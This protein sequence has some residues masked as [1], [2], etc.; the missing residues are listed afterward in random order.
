M[1]SDKKP[2]LRGKPL[3]ITHPELV[4]QWDD[5]YYSPN[6]LSFGSEVKIRWKCQNCQHQWVRSPNAR[7]STGIVG[8][9]PVCVSGHLHSDGRNSLANTHP[10]ISQDFHPTKNIDFDANE[11]VAGTSK[12]IWWKC[13]VC[14]FEWK[15]SGAHRAN[16]GRNCKACNNQA[17]KPDKS[18]SLAIAYPNL[19]E[20][21][22]YS[23]NDH[24]SPFE[25]T[26]GGTLKIWWKCK[27]CDH[28]WKGRISHRSY[29]GAGCPCCSGNDVH[30]D[31]RNSMRNSHPK[32]AIEFHPSKNQNMTPD[33]VKAGTGR[34]IWW[35]CQECEHEW[36]VAGSN[37]VSQN[38][39]CPACAGKAIHID[40][41][42]SLANMLPELAIEWHPTRNINIT[43]ATTSVG[44]N[45]SIWWICDCCEHEWKTRVSHRTGVGSDCPACAGKAVHI[46][47]RNSMTATHPDLVREWHPIKNGNLTSN[48]VIAGTGKKIWWLCKMCDG[49][50]KTSGSERTDSEVRKGTGCPYCSNVKIHPDGRNSLAISFP[51]LL[52]EWNYDKNTRIDPEKVVFGTHRKAWWKCDTCDGE[53]RTGIVNR[54]RVGTG[55]PSCANYGFDPILP[56]YY[57]CME[58]SGTDGIWWYKGGIAADV[59]FRKGRI[60]SSLKSKG[61]HLNVKIA[62]TIHFEHGRDAKKFESKMLSIKE[63]RQTILE[64]FDGSS[65]L[66]S[67]NPIIYAK[68]NA[69]ME[70]QT[71]SNQQTLHDFQ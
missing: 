70:E 24:L 47:G 50:W 54:T 3:S 34:K 63:I 52:S 57:Y 10:D 68:Q 58:I 65:E 71:K 69:L 56:A 45:K 49:D 29:S 62:S 36:K 27:A 18:N 23:K 31:G 9:C 2:R 19:E 26:Q 5:E 40:G 17:V 64:K 11:I 7:T 21:F 66:F 35:I 42:N 59:E 14:A 38:S 43:P 32:L 60:K 16:K 39:G 67:V 51:G 41:R 15:A 33:N 25:L 1:S 12:K 20:D 55:C 13:H 44:S 8:G 48:D 28:S 6:N 22:D 4:E 61:M 30:S 53:W 46:D 37:R